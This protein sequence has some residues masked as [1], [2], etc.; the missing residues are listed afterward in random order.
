MGAAWQIT[1]S[2]SDVN[3]ARNLAHQLANLHDCDP[4]TSQARHI[5]AEII[6]IETL[7][8][9]AGIQPERQP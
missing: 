9:R 8:M 6:R 3:A 5:A 7:L 2:P 1:W 4:R